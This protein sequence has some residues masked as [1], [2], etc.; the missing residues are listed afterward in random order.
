MKFIYSLV[1]SV[2]FGLELVS[3]KPKPLWNAIR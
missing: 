1:Y 3:L 2:L